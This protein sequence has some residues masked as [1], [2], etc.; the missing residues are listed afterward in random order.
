MGS[1]FDILMNLCRQFA[2]WHVTFFEKEM[3]VTEGLTAVENYL[4]CFELSN[5]EKLKENAA[6]TQVIPFERLNY[7]RN[8]LYVFNSLF[9]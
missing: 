5:L 1:V 7:L 4:K 8:Y 9:K 6:I 2:K 3:R